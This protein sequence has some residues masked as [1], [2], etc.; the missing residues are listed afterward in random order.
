M[1]GE[2]RSGKKL[3]ITLQAI[4]GVHVT[5][6]R[7]E[8]LHACRFSAHIR[9]T[10][11]AGLEKVE[12]GHKGLQDPTARQAFVTFVLKGIS[13]KD[14]AYRSFVGHVRRQNYS[15]TCDHAKSATGTGTGLKAATDL[16]VQLMVQVLVDL[17]GVPVLAQQPPQHPQTPH[18]Q[19][20]G[21]QPGLPCS[22]PLTCTP[23]PISAH[24]SLSQ[25]LS[26]HSLGGELRHAYHCL[27]MMG[28]RHH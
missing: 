11:S 22:L 21:G 26:T 7:E 28:Y 15:M 27:G 24:M 20:L 5:S 14:T 18:P 6:R 2:A 4:H 16:Q 13:L 19:H 3:V 1:P 9:Q 10:Q 23:N 25:Q 17:L 12:A 8:V